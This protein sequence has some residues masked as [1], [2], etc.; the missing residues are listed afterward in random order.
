M[1]GGNLIPRP[2]HSSVFVWEGLGMRLGCLGA[3]AHGSECSYV[4]QT[5]AGTLVLIPSNCWLAILSTMPCV[6]V[7][8]IGELW[9]G[10]AGSTLSCYV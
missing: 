10:S 5:R 3:V 4:A 7:V 8:C 1:E 6:F 2:S 9:M